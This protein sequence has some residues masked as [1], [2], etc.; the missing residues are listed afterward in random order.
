MTPAAPD[1]QAPATLH[2]PVMAEEMGQ[3]LLSKTS[4]SPLYC[5]ATFG[6]G[7]YTR[8]I[9]EHAP[10]ARVIA[11]DRDR[12]AVTAGRRWAEEYPLR[13]HLVHTRFSALVSALENA[14]IDRLDGIV[15]DLGL[16]SDQIEE[17]SRGFSLQKDGALDMRMDRTGTDAASVVNHCDE[18]ALAAVFRDG[19]ERRFARRFAAAIVHAREKQPITSTVALAEILRRAARRAM[20]AKPY[21][22]TIDPATVAFQ[23]LRIHVND[24]LR[25]LRLALDA[26][27]ALLK[28]GGRLVVVSFHSLEDGI[29]KSF[30]KRH[31][32]Q[33]PRPSRHLPVPEDRTEDSETCF[34]ILTAKP[35]RP[36]AEEISLNP[37]AR[38][39]RLR[40]GERNH[41]PWRTPRPDSHPHR[42][43][44]RQS[45]G[46]GI[47]L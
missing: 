7:G 21:R 40:A 35:V 44:G 41:T 22:K 3:W 43:S 17:S 19:G 18:K 34:R 45:A 36:S 29:V 9:L 26:T 8:W 31:S 47:L 13:L 14:G 33:K 15:F 42:Q 4:D 46:E 11:L 10:A 27:G 25:E 38:S 24:E 1:V 5:D 39:A 6:G 30:L 32:G 23:A 37:R 20:G 2:R 12:S 28:P 16:S